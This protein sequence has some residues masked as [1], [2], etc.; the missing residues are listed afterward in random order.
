MTRFD[1]VPGTTTRERSAEA[2]GELRAY[3]CLSS[4]LF[5]LWMGIT[6][7]GCGDY[8]LGWTDG[9]IP[10]DDVL[11]YTFL[12]AMAIFVVWDGWNDLRR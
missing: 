4:V 11:V 8:T 7:V 9:F 3:G 5:R 6:L 1:P 2:G 10:R 12:A